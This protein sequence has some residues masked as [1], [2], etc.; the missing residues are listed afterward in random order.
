MTDIK[1]IFKVNGKPFY[2]V[3]GQARNNSGYNDSES[4]TAFKG[5]K[6]VHGNTLEIQVYWEQVEPEEGKFDFASVDALLARA[7]QYEVRLILLWFAT[8]KNANMDF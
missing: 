4:E 6:L 1:R 7:R 5:V 3:G 2:P 8:W